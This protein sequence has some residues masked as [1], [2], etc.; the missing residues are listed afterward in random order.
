M[1]DWSAESSDTPEGPI[2]VQPCGTLD[3][4]SPL[5]QHCFP[6]DLAHHFVCC[7]DIKLPEMSARGTYGNPVYYS[8]ESASD[9]KSYSWC[10]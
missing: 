3:L 4:D 8:I 10:T 1:D 5:T 9:S 6:Y 7:V 2:K